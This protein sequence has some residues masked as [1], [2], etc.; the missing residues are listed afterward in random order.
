HYL[1]DE[2][3][4]ERSHLFYF[5]GPRGVGKRTAAAAICD[6]LGVPLLYVDISTLYHQG[7]DEARFR[8]IV[9]ECLL[10]SSALLLRDVDILFSHEASVVRFRKALLHDVTRHCALVF[11]TGSLPD[12]SLD[13]ITQAR[14]MTLHFPAPDYALRKIIWEQTLQDL[15]ARSNGLT[16]ETLAGKFKFTPG[17][18]QRAVNAAQDAAMVRGDDQSAIGEVELLAGCR[19]QCNRKLSELAAKVK[20]A[21]V[22]DD[23]ILPPDPLEQLQELCDQFK[24]RALVY[25]A[26]GF[27][28]KIAYGT[29]LNVLFA[30]ASGTGKTMAAGII[31]HALQLE[32]YKI[33]LSGIVSKYIGETEKN[34][35]QIFHE[36][37]TA[38]AILFFDEA[39]ALFGK[40]TEVKDAHDR[41]ANIETSYLLQQMEAYEGLTILATNLRQNIDDAFGRRMQFIIEFPFPDATQRQRIWQRMFPA[42]APVSPEV[43]YAFLAQRLEMAGG[44]IKNI[45]LRAAFYAAQNG[46]DIGMEHI[47][48]SAKRE[49]THTGKAF[50][51]AEFDTY[52]KKAG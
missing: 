11:M 25:D 31:A 9:R 50:F 3:C 5:A 38:N 29:G 17:Q 8:R 47:L 14:Y 48:R 46:T 35:S 45:A 41:Y 24:Q 26:W 40:R 34:L 16:P 28:R 2:D 15:P 12:A 1:Q 10:H 6:A 13:D 22:W 44:N 19:A 21:G 43:D 27:N 51:A 36:A 49:Y 20:P 37:E 18:I 4:P 30:G 23:L 39:D 52:I 7:H 33:D 32:L 42:N